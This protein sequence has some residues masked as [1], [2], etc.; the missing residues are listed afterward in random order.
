MF[1]TVQRS[2]VP[3]G[4]IAAPGTMPGTDSYESGKNRRSGAVRIENGTG[5]MIQATRDSESSEGLCM[6]K[7]LN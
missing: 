6:P 5:A 7:F 2:L 4:S 1:V 3:E